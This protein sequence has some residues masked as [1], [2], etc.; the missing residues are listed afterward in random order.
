MEGTLILA[1]VAQRYRLGLVPGHL[2][3]PQPHSTL[4]P[5]HGLMMTLTPR[6]CYES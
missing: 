6:A 1:M 3:E 4:R 2:I 5:R